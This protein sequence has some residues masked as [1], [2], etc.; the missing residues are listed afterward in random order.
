MTC[1]RAALTWAGFQIS[2]LRF[3]IFQTKDQVVITSEYVHNVRNIWMARKEHLDGLEFW[4]GDTIGRW[5]GEKTYFLCVNCHNPHS[6]RFKGV[7]ELEVAGKKTTAPTSEKIKP[8][9]RPRRPEE[10]R[11]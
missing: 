11:P 1:R 3:Q 6:P 4:N 10:M 7:V 5:D 8:E 9:P 2:D